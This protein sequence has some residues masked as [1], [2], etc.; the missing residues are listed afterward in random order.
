MPRARRP[1]TATTR[2]STPTTPGRGC[3]PERTRGERARRAAHR[4]VLRQHRPGDP[5]RRGARTARSSCA[6]RRAR[7]VTLAHGQDERHRGQR[8]PAR[9]TGYGAEILETTADGLDRRGAARP[10]P[11]R[12]RFARVEVVD[13]MRPARRGRTRS[14]PG[15]RPARRSPRTSFDLLVIGGGVIGAATAA[16]AA[17][18]GL[19]RGALVD[20]GD[21]GSGTSS[22][23]SKLD[24]R[25]PALP[26]AR[27]RPARPRGA[28]RAAH[29]DRPS[30]R[31][32][33]C[34]GCR[35]SCRS[36]GAARSGPRSCRAGSSSTRRSRVS[37]LNWLVQPERAGELVPALRRDGL[38]SCALYADAWTND[39]R[40]CLENV[41]AA[42]AARRHGRS[43][44]RRSSR[45][46]STA[47][48]CAGAEVGVDGEAVAVRGARGRQRRGA[49]GRRTC[50][51]SRIRGPGRPCG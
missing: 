27:R 38:R 17:R 16:H 49:V 33:S 20:A 25:R 42:A 30:S 8:G 39:A 45:C 3:A 13:A 5:R 11:R 35:S 47:G 41:V 50:G 31:R 1:T 14:D 15:G 51:G 10:C 28:P 43:T 18:E 24:P 37:R 34:T 4:P 40:L 44:A 9:A 7:S 32:T 26:P 6:A 29:A 46:R 19:S 36:T 22:A 12:R 23:S 2:A 48:R 21:F